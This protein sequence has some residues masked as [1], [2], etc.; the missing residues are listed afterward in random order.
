MTSSAH[1][2]EE[3]RGKILEV[4]LHGK[5]GR[6]DYEEFIPETER[7]IRQHGKISILVEM[8]DFHGWDGGALWEDLKWNAQHFKDIERLAIVGEETW[9]R[10]MTGFCKPFTNAEVRYFEPGRLEEARAWVA[11]SQVVSRAPELTETPADAEHLG[12]LVL[13]YM[14]NHPLQQLNDLLAMKHSDKITPELLSAMSKLTA[15]E[16][17]ALKRAI[18]SIFAEDVRNYSRRWIG[19]WS[20]ARSC[21]WRMANS[22]S[23]STCLRGTIG[24]ATSIA[25][26][27][28]R[29]TT[30]SVADSNNGAGC[31]L[32]QPA[33]FQAEFYLG[34]C[35]W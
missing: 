15:E 35:I 10:W 24:S 19:P 11:G 32:V 20:E 13:G 6:E 7:L 26:A 4:H 1:V 23:G 17:A 3:V 18:T 34:G 12:I 30:E 2:D 8:H 31:T 5:L 22:P 28:R 21:V 33:V 9:H 29:C 14:W 16:K 27:I 25:R